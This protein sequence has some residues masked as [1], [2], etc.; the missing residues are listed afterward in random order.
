MGLEEGEPR[1]I[2]IEP[3]TNGD[4]APATYTLPTTAKSPEALAPAK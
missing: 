4:V 1:V 3:G 2:A